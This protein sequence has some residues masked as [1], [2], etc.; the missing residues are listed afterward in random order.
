MAIALLAA[1]LFAAAQA[2]PDPC[3]SL[4]I[5]QARAA[6]VALRAAELAHRG[7]SGGA[8]RIT[9][10][11]SRALEAHLMR[12]GMV[13]TTPVRLELD[14]GPTS[15]S[16]PPAL[17]I[18]ESAGPKDPPRTTITTRNRAARQT[19]SDAPFIELTAPESSQAA[20]DA[21]RWFPAAVAAAGLAAGPTCRPGAPIEGDGSTLTPIAFTD[22]SGST[23]SV[24]V[25]DQHRIARIEV[26]AADQRL[27]DVCNWVVFGHWQQREGRWIPGTIGRFTVRSSTTERYDLTLV[28][29]APSDF[30]GSLPPPHL[31]DIATWNQPEAPGGIE[32]I[33]LGQSLWSVEVAAA[34]SRILLIERRDDLVLLGAPDGDEVC[35]SLLSS[36]SARFPSKPHG[37]VALS[38]H[39]P[40]PAGGLRALAARGATILIPTRLEPFVRALLARPATLGGP[41]V[42]GPAEPRLSLF[43]DQTTIEGTDVRCIDIGEHSAHAFC[44]VVF[45]FPEPGIIYEHDLGYFPAAGQ[46]R[47]TP[48]LAG[49]VDQLAAAGIQPQRLIQAW[50]VKRTLPEIPW[51]TVADLARAAR[52]A[53][54]R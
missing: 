10:E 21:A 45:Y 53:G 34:D 39:H 25:D 14:L 9:Y 17:A 7:P 29:A 40:S 23:V 27:G 6:L 50:P 44:Y 54:S 12:P 20:A 22:A 38:H 47:F 19:S 26:L 31:A 37:L 32:F 51:S 28:D 30:A 24:F 13:Y 52:E 33:P 8:F 2:A 4:T 43:D 49:L 15:P 41:A 1:I 36:L 42:P 5:V 11:G 18:R 16:L 46:P 35:T 3:D 48:R